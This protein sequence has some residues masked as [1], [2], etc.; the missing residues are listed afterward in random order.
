MTGRNA[1]IP[2]GTA[3][4]DDADI[5]PEDIRNRLVSRRIPIP[6]PVIRRIRALAPQ[7]VTCLTGGRGHPGYQA[8]QKERISSIR[9]ISMRPFM[10]CVCTQR[11][12]SRIAAIGLVPPTAAIATYCGLTGTPRRGRF[13]IP[14]SRMPE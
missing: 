14:T 5:N 1:L 10:A 11:P 12:L 2:F 4:G 13:G 8:V 7:S 3:T 6:D 9:V